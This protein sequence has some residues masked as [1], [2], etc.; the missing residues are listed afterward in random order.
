MVFFWDKREAAEVKDKAFERDILGRIYD[1]S[2]TINSSFEQ[3]SVDGGDGIGDPL[4]DFGMPR[5]ADAVVVLFGREERIARIDVAF[6]E[7]CM[8]GDDQEITKDADKGLE[9]DY[10]ICVVHVDGVLVEL[11]KVLN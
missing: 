9:S 5:L 7:D 8:D 3:L 2:Y 1:E 10:D 11:M 6:V 4:A